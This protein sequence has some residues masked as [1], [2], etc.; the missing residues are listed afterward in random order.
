MAQESDT[1]GEAAP[2]QAWQS[3][4][5]IWAWF[6]FVEGRERTLVFEFTEHSK[7]E[8]LARRWWWRAT[9]RPL[10]IVPAF[11]GGMLQQLAALMH[12]GRWLHVRAGLREFWPSEAKYAQRTPPVAFWG[13]VQDVDPCPV[14]GGSKRDLQLGAGRKPSDAPSQTK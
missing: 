6:E 2:G 3:N 11:L 8:P 9:L 12:D 7:S 5:H 13:Q 4:C 14:C 1:Q 10:S